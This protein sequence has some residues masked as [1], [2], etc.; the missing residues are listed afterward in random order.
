MS[1]ADLKD[2]MQPNWIGAAEALTLATLFF[3]YERDARSFIIRRAGLGR[4]RTRCLQNWPSDMQN[5]HGSG[6]VPLAFWSHFER[7][8][9]KLLEDWRS[10]DFEWENFFDSDCQ[11]LKII[12]A[13]VSKTDLLLELPKLPVNWISAIEALAR[14]DLV[15][16]DPHIAIAT[17]AH[18]GLIRT[19]AKLLVRTNYRV[20][21]NG[22]TEAHFIELDKEFWWAKGH[23]ALNQNWRLG[24]F[25]TSIKRD[26][27]HLQAFGVEFDGGAIDALAPKL[28]T[29]PAQSNQDVEYPTIDAPSPKPLSIPPDDEIKAKML[30]LIDM[31]MRRDSAAKVIR[32]IAGFEGV[33]NAHARRV[34]EGLLELG[35]PVNK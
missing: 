3:E 30:E 14:M 34:V 27:V 7:A 4:I 25:T 24:D 32:Q 9:T 13:E 18:A 6:P 21:P 26:T 29:G 28:A 8:R 31:P 19:R 2:R 10:G 16:H 15:T 35:R 33:G 22:T 17:R 11:V 12:G 20:S 23:A 5:A 1:L